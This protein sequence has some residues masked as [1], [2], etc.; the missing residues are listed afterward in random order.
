LFHGGELSGEY[1]SFFVIKIKPLHPDGPGY[2]FVH[3][4]NRPELATVTQDAGHI[5]KLTWREKRPGFSILIKL[6]R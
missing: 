6:G 4:F 3:L 1:L 2:S 5:I